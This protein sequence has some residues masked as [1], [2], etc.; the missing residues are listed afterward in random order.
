MSSARFP[1]LRLFTRLR[2]KPMTL[3]T[4]RDASCSAPV[5]NLP[6]VISYLTEVNSDRPLF[7]TLNEM[8]ARTRLDR[9]RY[10]EI[11]T[12]AGETTL[13]NVGRG[14]DNTE[15]AR[16]VMTGRCLVPEDDPDPHLG[17]PNLKPSFGSRNGSPEKFKNLSGLTATCR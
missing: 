6:Q 9:Y 15:D 10:H 5:V 1:K 16:G 13:E 11:P 12:K 7:A 14:L 3:E 8:I 2:L 4:A 17:D